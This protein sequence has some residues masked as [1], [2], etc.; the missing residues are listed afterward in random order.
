MA[1]DSVLNALAMGIK[2]EMEGITVY[3]GAAALCD[4]EVK[5]FFLKQA[6]EE[7]LHYNWLLEFYKKLTEDEFSMLSFAV[8]VSKPAAGST[9]ITDDFLRMIGEDQHLSTAITTAILLE[10]S[11]I[12]HYRKSAEEANDPAVKELFDFLCDWEKDHYDEL[13]KIQEESRQYWFDAQEFVPF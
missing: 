5:A 13:L 1:K 12:E 9:I 6:E 11:A 2:G 10:Y 3:N 8:N 4:G 7:K